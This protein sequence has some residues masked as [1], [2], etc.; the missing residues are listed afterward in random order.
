MD[1]YADRREAEA[2]TH[3]QTLLIVLGVLLPTFMGSLDQTILATALPT[4]GR[5][6]DDMHSLPWLI[7]AYLLASTAIIPLYGKLADIHGRRFTLRIALLTYMAGSLVCALAPSMLVLI[8]GRVLHGLGGGGLSSMGMIVLADLVSPKER[9]RYYGY[10]AATYTTAGGCG[11]LLGGL[12]ADHLHW[13]VIF[14]INIPMG[15][16]ALAIT[17]SLLRR[18]PRYERPHLL[19]IVGAA[20]IVIASVS[21]MLALN[22]AGVRYPWTSPPILA[23]F[24]V[25]LIMGALFV[26]RLL[27]APEPLIPV[28]ILKNPIVCCAIVANAFGWGSI[29]GLNVF[30]P[31]YLQG[32][33][34]LSATQAG[35]SLMVLMVALNTSAGLAGAGSRPRAALQAP[36]HGR[37]LALDRSDCDLGVARERHDPAVVRGH[38][39]LDRSRVRADA[40]A[41]R[42]RPAERGGTPS[43]R[44]FGGNHELQPQPVRD[45][46][47]RGV[48]RHRLGRHA[49]GS[50]AR[51]RLPG[52]KSRRSIRPAVPGG[53]G[54]H[55]DC[56][57]RDRGDGRKAAADRS[58]DRGEL[59]TGSG[60][61]ALDELDAGRR[62]LV[63]VHGEALEQV[64]AESGAER[65]VG[66]V[67][68]A[69][70]HDAADAGNVVAGIERVPAAAEIDLEPGAEIH[71]LGLG[72]NADV[73]EIAG[74]IARRDVHAAAQRDRQVG[75]VAAHAVALD[76][77]VGGGPGGAGVLVAEADVRM[78]EIADRLHACRAAVPR[79]R[80][81]VPS[82][83]PRRAGPNPRSAHP[84]KF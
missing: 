47:D 17:T 37:A 43:A 30:L 8:F 67:A 14:W 58:R 16:A 57:D 38:V 40:L 25:A 53:G 11:P 59:A 35:L 73:A 80:V 71:R 63:G 44:H 75:K 68:P 81:R 60:H 64:R 12:I 41:D 45:H 3:R 15:L 5:D 6:F 28:S 33:M 82:A 49:G 32:V 46:A 55:V 2:L 84:W 83:R 66:G 26:L 76:H 18:L 1:A 34:G 70:H 42:G 24:A 51:Q 52:R 21:F 56:A 61:H 7:T 69:R 77:D 36:T 9:G 62:R 10:F 74:A 54:E 78:N 13:S 20:L 19:D 4:I 23:L 27:T 65:H 29:I 22:L 72:R 48:R 39:D 79:S 31:M 50:I